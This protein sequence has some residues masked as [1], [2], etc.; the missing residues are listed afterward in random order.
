MEAELVREL[1][2][3][4]ARVELD[5]AAAARMGRAAYEKYVQCFCRRSVAEVCKGIL[6]SD[7]VPGNIPC[8]SYEDAITRRAR[9]PAAPPTNF[10]V[11]L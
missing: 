2:E 9:T 3:V 5:P 11:Q 4:I 8:D 1:P 10:R 6:L 7:A